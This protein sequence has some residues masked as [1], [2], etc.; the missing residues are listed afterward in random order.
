MAKNKKSPKMMKVV[1]F[2]ET[3]ATDYITIQNGG[4]IDWTTTENKERLA[5]T[6]YLIFDYPYKYYTFKHFEV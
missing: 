2:D 3:A 5:K 1:Y 4:Q 6:L